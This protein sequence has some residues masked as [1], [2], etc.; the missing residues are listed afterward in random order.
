MGSYR[1]SNSVQRRFS[2][3]IAERHGQPELLDDRS[4]CRNVRQESFYQ[5]RSVNPRLREPQ[6]EAATPDA[7]RARR[8]T[9]G[10]A[11]SESERSMRAG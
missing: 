1:P 6:V 8:I 9:I 2:E 5:H 7:A 3:L 11:C 4:A 10:A